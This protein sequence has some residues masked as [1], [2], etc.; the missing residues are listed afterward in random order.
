VV[1]GDPA[2]TH[3]HKYIPPS[4][5]E[6]LEVHSARWYQETY[7]MMVTDSKN[8]LLFP[9]QIYTNATPTDAMQRFPI[10]PVMFMTTLLKRS[11]RKKSGLW[12]HLGSIPPCDDPVA[13]PEQAGFSERS[14]SK[15]LSR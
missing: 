3:F 1:N 14:N 11:D 15:I 6:Q 9:I 4:V 2:E 10:E 7:N 5:Q 8:D 13:T 12:R